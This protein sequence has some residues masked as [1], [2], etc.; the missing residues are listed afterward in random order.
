MNQYRNLNLESICSKLNH[1][2]RFIIY[3]FDC[4][5]QFVQYLDVDNHIQLIEKYKRV[6]EDLSKID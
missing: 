1:D 4:L 2:S 6:V 5:E 3:S